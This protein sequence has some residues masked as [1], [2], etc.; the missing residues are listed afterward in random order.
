MS[1]FAYIRSMYCGQGFPNCTIETEIWAEEAITLSFCQKL[2]LSLYLLKIVIKK[3]NSQNS[4]KISI[5]LS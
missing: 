4:D 2:V 3:L 1:G 5:F